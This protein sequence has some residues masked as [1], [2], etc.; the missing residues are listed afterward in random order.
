[1]DK[2]Y[3]WSTS[4]HPTSHERIYNIN[5]RIAM[6]G[7]EDEAIDLTHALND[8]PGK[9]YQL[10]DAPDEVT[11]LIE[12]RDGKFITSLPA[13]KHEQAHALLTLLNR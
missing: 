10:S 2:P 1:M 7:A 6:L 4:L 12:D 5:F 8:Q 11:I 3:H 13:A 9:P